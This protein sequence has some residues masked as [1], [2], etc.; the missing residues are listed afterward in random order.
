[1]TRP[2]ARSNAGTTRTCCPA[3]SWPSRC[4]GGRPLRR[5]GRLRHGRRADEPSPVRFGTRAGVR[6]GAG[7][8]RTGAPSPVSRVLAVSVRLLHRAM[9]GLRLVVS[10][11]DTAEGHHGGI[12]QANGW[13]YLGAAVTHS[14]RVRGVWSI[15]GLALP[16]RPGWAVDPMAARRHVDPKAERVAR[17]PKHKYAQ[18]LDAEMRTALGTMAQPYPRRWCSSQHGR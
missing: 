16:L 18:G 12:Y 4:V 13:T 9:P 8:A 10:F 1:M 7:R 14:Y 2:A 5:R 15:R 6:A 17:P 3:G 11:A